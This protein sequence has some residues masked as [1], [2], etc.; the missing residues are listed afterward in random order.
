MA[1]SQTKG[2]TTKSGCRRSTPR[3][4]RRIEIEIGLSIIKFDFTRIF[5]CASPN[6]NELYCAQ[7][8]S[9]RS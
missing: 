7:A 9:M 1:I 6:S 5:I 2:S 3:T 4:C 8:G